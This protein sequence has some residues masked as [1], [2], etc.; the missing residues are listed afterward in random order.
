MSEDLRRRVEDYLRAHHVAT[1][2]TTAAA[3]PWAAAVF[4][5]SAG[6][7]LYFLSSPDSRHCRNLAQDARAAA[8]VQAD[9]SDWPE[10]KGVQLEGKVELLSG[11]EEEQARHLYAEKFPLVGKLGEA[12]AAIVKALARVRWYRLAPTRLWFI[13]NARGFG[14]RDELELG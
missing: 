8:T 4:Y 6:T 13:D 9:Y 7:T 3:G 14:R 12:P 2:A 11:S 5:A 10:I 1:L